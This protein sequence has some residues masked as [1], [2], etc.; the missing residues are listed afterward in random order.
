L[1]LDAIADTNSRSRSKI[2]TGEAIVDRQPDL[3]SNKGTAPRFIDMFAQI[4]N[5]GLI[6]ERIHSDYDE[7]V[8][9]WKPNFQ[10]SSRR[11]KVARFG[12][13]NSE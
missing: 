7:P 2:M 12:G 1:L 3:S 10:T 13:L 6:K 5:I 9:V 8:L 11:G 4:R